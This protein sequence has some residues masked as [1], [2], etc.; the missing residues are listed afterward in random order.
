MLELFYRAWAN[1]RPTV[2]F[3]RPER[4]QFS[5]YVGALLGLAGPALRDAD[6]W[7]D[8]AKVYFSGMLAAGTRTRAGLESLIGEYLDLP[9]QVQECVG[10]WLTLVEAERMSLANCETS[11]LGRSVLGERI[12]SAQH[13]VRLRIGPMDV[14]QLLQYLPGS[15]SLGRL[16][17]AVMNYLGYE[18][19]WD[20]Q[21]IVQRDRAPGVRLGQFG[22]LG[23]ST[24]MAPARE[25]PDLD[26]VTIDASARSEAA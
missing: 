10:E 18:Y 17:A 16:R 23:W 11:T 24:W 2:Q 7:P 1:V 19:A 21:L 6:E 15:P 25:G 22:H 8:R 3:D 26:D 12:W 14:G 20:L 13:K 9:V 4:D 5:V